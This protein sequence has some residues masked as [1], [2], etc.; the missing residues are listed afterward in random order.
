MPI[1]RFQMP[2]GR[3]GR[4]EV[5]EGLSPEQATSLIEKELG[6]GAPK[7]AG[8]SKERSIGEAFTDV[9]AGLKSGAGSL[10]QLPS[11][12]AGVVGGDYEAPGQETGLAAVGKELQAEAQALKSPGLKAREAARS[13]KVAVA[14]KR[15]QLDAFMTAFSETIRDPG[16][17]TNFL[18]EQA[19]QLIPS[20]GA[21]RIIKPLAGTAA[22]VRGAIGTGAVQQG[23]DIAA[24]TYEQVYNELIKKGVGEEEAAGRAL[25]LARTAGAGAATISLLAQRLPGAKAIEEAFAGQ[26]GKLGRVFGAARAGLGEATGEVAE[27]TPAKALQNYLMSQGF[28]P[29]GMEAPTPG[30]SLTAGLGETAAMAALGGAGMGAGVGLAQR[31]AGAEEAPPEQQ[32]PSQF[33]PEPEGPPPEPPALP[34]AAVEP[35]MPP[36]LP[37]PVAAVEPGMPPVEPAPVEPG[38]PPTPTMPEPPQDAVAAMQ[39]YWM[40][41]PADFGMSFSDIQNRDRSRPA[42]IQQMNSI[43]RR[44]DYNRLSVSRDFGAGAP[45]VI[46]DL[47]IDGSRLGR[48][49]T[50]SASDGTQIPVQYAVVDA[51]ELTPS[52]RADGSMVPEYAAPDFMGIRPVAGNGR[53]A[54]IQ[55]MY[56]EGPYGTYV[57][58][59][60]NDTAH[61]ISSEVIS[62]IEQPVLVRIMP[63]SSLTPDIAD[64]SNVGGQLGMSPTEQA[65]IDMGRFDLQGIEFLANGNPSAASLRQF[66]AAMPPE[67]QGN[68]INAEGQP[69]P[70]AKMR[71]SNA[72]FARAYAND[73]LI[74]LYA[75][76]T[77]PEAKQILNGMAIAAPAMSN[78]SEAGEY[79]IRQYVAKAAELAVNARRQ[80]VD[81]ATYVDQ[82]DIDM[83]PLTREVV[84]MF[85][86]NKNAPRRI[87]DSLVALAAEANR[88]AEQALAPPDM[89]GDVA[90]KRPLEDVF[91]ILRN[92][93]TQVAPIVEEEEAPEKLT[94]QIGKSEE[95]IAQEIDGMNVVQVADWLV[96]NAP[97]SFAKIVSEA[98]RSRVKAMQARKI[99][100]TFKLLR[101]AERKEKVYGAVYGRYIGNVQFDVTINAPTA[102][103][104][105]AEVVGTEYRTLL[106]EMLHLATQ[107]QIHIEIG[108]GRYPTSGPIYELENL[109]KFIMKKVREDRAA[110]RP[111]PRRLNREQT[112]LDV[113]ELIS[114]GFT[115]VEVQQYLASITYKKKNGFTRFVDAIR[116]LMAINK[117]DQT[118]MER[119]VSLTDEILEVP[120]KD[121]AAKLK[122]AGVRFGVGAIG[123]P[124]IAETRTPELL[125]KPVENWFEGVEKAAVTQYKGKNKL[126][127]MPIDT[128]LKLAKQDTPGDR[129]DKVARVEKIIDENGKF[130]S[131]PYLYIE[132]DSKGNAITTG[133]EGRHRAR[134][135]KALGYSTIPVELRSNIR[136]SEQQ[137]PESFDYQKNWP[138]TLVG[139]NGDV[140]PFPV[141]REDS[142]AS[143]TAGLESTVITEEREPFADIPEDKLETPSRIQDKLEEKWDRMKT[144]APKN[145]PSSFSDVDEDLWKDISP[146]FFPQNKNIV[147]KIDGMR[148]RFWQRLAQGVADQY[149]TIK[150]YDP[151]A[152]MKARMSK[153]IDGAL[154]GI[155]FEGEVKLTDGALDIAKDT[156]GL[157]KAMEPVG[158]EVD[159]Y[160]I[161]VALQ[162]DAQLVAQGKAPSVNKDIVRR[163]NE[164]AAGKIGDKSRL[165]VYQQVQKDMNKLN[166][167]VLRIALQ[168]GIIDKE[169]F[170]VFA[171]DINYIPFYKVMDE[172]G[173]VQA[174]ATKSG[175]VNQ[176]F[177]KALQGGEKPFGDLMENTLRNWSHILSASMKNEAANATVKAAMDVG[178]A[179][180]NLKVGLEWRLDDDGR[181]GKVY[182]AKTGEM[183][184]DGS[185]KPE[186]TSSDG[187]G[188]V[189]TMID[190]KPAYFEIIDPLLIEAIMSIGYMGPKSKFLDIARDFK[191]ILQFGVTVSPAFK[192]RNLIRDSVQSAAV[193]GIGLN[194]AKNVT[195]GIAASKKGNPDYI[196]A[197]AG[198]AI[199]N[200]G[201]YVEGDQAT[202]IKR[203]IAQGVKGENILDTEAKIKAGLKRMWD[204]YQDWGN[205]SEAA[206]R[207]ALYLQLREKGFSHLEASFQARDLLDFSMQGSWPAVRML[208]QVVPFLNARVQGLYK[209]GRDGITPT[210]R[211][212]YNS[213]TGKPIDITDKQK[214]Q[215]FSIVSGAV[216]LASLM[217]YMSFKDDEEWKKRE[218]WDRDNFW[219]FKMP[220]MD[221]AIRIPKPFEIGA[222]G[223][224]AERIAEQMMDEG[225]EGKVFAKSLS[226]MLTDTFAI[227][228]IPQAFKPL[229]D[230]YA[231]KDSFTGAP[232]ETAGMERLTKAERVAVGTSPLAKALSK[233]VNV[234]L[235]ESTELSPV[236]ADYAVKAYLG[237]MGATISATSHYAVMPFSKSAYPDHNWAETVS[238]GF[239][240]SLPAAQSGYVTSFYENM[241][242]IS[243][244]YADMRHY[245]QLGESDKMK[246]VFEEKGD[247][248]MLA[249]MY[250]Q[251]SKDMAKM[252][253]VIQIIQRDEN[254]DGAQK[255]EEIDRLKMLIGDL[256]KMAEETR[257]S[258]TKQYKA[259]R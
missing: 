254:M 62:Q 184:G 85:A 89:F 189:K 30:S 241:K 243:Q 222:I 71:L 45:V 135:L 72:L 209:L 14:E 24:G 77:D 56:S 249:K 47:E 99:P 34:G 145:K 137:D 187:R 81:L 142:A 60:M 10:L 124:E 149:R 115:E 15:G 160:Q 177:S 148:D 196:S 87:G 17:L 168:Q 165:E 46:S 35:E 258:I 180:P 156:K 122:A 5:P 83:D 203:L 166:R 155:L 202:M 259:S 68:L 131:V 79:D 75:E 129:R 7:P 33:A 144:G 211:V 191:N 231:N 130:S 147:Q 197:L 65:K 228:P 100:M 212:I 97:N 20:L 223:T 170:N 109:R 193:S 199:F 63:K 120:A 91:A 43:A 200:F 159:R 102:P 161:W 117:V 50:V 229:V 106:H 235:P 84:S 3:I 169:A 227:N 105:K 108:K 94:Y 113:H 66:I 233:V 104:E 19:P 244:A 6:L 114:Y 239:V 208:T 217:L 82:G 175:L 157:L 93:P 220:G 53:V 252:R 242:T 251:A 90:V 236:Q 127:Q 40:G 2:D 207:M 255:K 219:W 31:Q 257:V 29:L 164:L 133:H 174:A 21:A 1:A 128:F 153:T 61:G 186:Y 163:R 103:G 234:F 138:A 134:A 126:V 121:V 238:L 98:V 190:G 59:L 36:L 125:T 11:Q 112:L 246:E 198:G 247:K 27:E 173:S 150:D 176:Y 49:D 154:E 245:A 18:A 171:R 237:W 181:N 172:G 221:A 26:E 216:V 67:E 240:K 23:A 86:A 92:E 183:V 118:A 22:A 179:F 214:A 88:A 57:D 194:I 52:N 206:N 70:L 12:V 96:D 16:L 25:G 152:Y 204:G 64:K 256:A 224:F 32:R 73:A 4:F 48:I 111:V 140:V 210:S 215:Q 80:G 41:S 95:Q 218:Q 76:A 230:L 188:L 146:V 226:R 139:E 54:G 28:A 9:Y 110:G 158:A 37:A 232:I 123:T 39:N 78:L 178:G 162:R 38:M 69:N 101:G 119:L 143:Y 167:S 136:W 182:S 116:K 44:P 74:D 8:P 192:V 51:R 201:S 213:I 13:E 55:K 248:I 151:V 132:I 205:R 225:A 141:A 185:L 58:A 253:Q 42:S 195:Q 107:G 250:D